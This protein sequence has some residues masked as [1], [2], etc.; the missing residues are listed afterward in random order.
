MKNPSNRAADKGNI[1]HKSLELLA[2]KKLAIQNNSQNFVEDE[3]GRLFHTSTFS[4]DESLDFAWWLYTEH[5]PTQHKWAKKDYRDCKIW[6]EEALTFNDGQ[7]S[8]LKRNVLVPE[9]YFDIEIREPWAAY[10]YVLPDGSKLEGYLRIK[11]TVDLVTSVNKSTIEYIDWKTGKVIDW[12]TGKEKNDQTLRDDPQLRMYHYA[13]SKLYPKVPHIIMSIFFL[14]FKAPFSLCF[15]QSDLKK[16]EEMLKKRFE[17]IRDTSRP[18]LNKSWR[19]TAFCHFGKH[20]QE[21]TDKTI[22]E[23]HKDELIELGIERATARHGQ[24]DAFKNYGE[25]GGRSDP[26]K[27]EKK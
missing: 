19:C 9:Q 1:V 8:P 6:M 14:Q 22:C 18:K 27:R 5:K 4:S 3:T 25:G 17:T 2:R 15:E 11:G 7:F 26:L 24:V 16:T 10:D 12:A 21:G 20:Q 13:L 23:Y